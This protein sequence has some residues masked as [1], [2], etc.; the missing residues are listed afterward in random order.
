MAHAALYFQQL[1]RAIDR[2]VKGYKGFAS[3]IPSFM[4]IALKNI[5]KWQIL[6]HVIA[7]DLHHAFSTSITK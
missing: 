4:I 5:R 6:F 3:V 7:L 2:Y 1:H